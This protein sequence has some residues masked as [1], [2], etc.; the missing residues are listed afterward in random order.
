M[1]TFSTESLSTLYSTTQYRV[2]RNPWGYPVE[3]LAH[4]Q[5]CR[6]GCCKKVAKA[7][8]DQQGEKKDYEGLSTDGR[9]EHAHTPTCRLGV[10]D[11]NKRIIP[12]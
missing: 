5:L 8:R 7:S 2:L 3:A 4:A 10:Y 6:C 12:R 9:V 11:T 1:G